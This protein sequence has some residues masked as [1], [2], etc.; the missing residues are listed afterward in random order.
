RLL[1]RTA[2]IFSAHSCRPV[3]ST[4]V[5]RSPS[6]LALAALGGCVVAKQS[7]QA[8]PNDETTVMLFTGGLGHPMDGIAR[9]PWFAVRDKGQT[10]WDIFE[11]GGGGTASDPTKNSPYVDS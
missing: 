4:S 9:H 1:Q 6:I 11:V 8:P 10:E 2:L 5:M 3:R 7:L